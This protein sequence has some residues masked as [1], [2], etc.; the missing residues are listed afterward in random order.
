[1]ADFL[2]RQAEKK[3]GQFWAPVYSAWLSKY[4]EQAE[5]HLPLPDNPDAHQ[6]TPDENKKLGAAITERKKVRMFLIR[7]PN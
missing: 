6:L 7:R 2:R 3:L 1:M 5:L 4:P